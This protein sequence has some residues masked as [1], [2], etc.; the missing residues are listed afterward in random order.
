MKI[1]AALSRQK[2]LWVCGLLA[3]CS[4][5]VVS[6]GAQSVAPRISSEIN[7]AETSVVRNSLHPLAQAQYDAGRMPADRR[8]NGISIVFNRSAA[9]E[10]DLQ[11]LIAAQQ[12]PSS[13]L[14]HQ[15]LTP[16]QFAVRFG[17]ADAD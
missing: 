8:L 1:I 16:D 9:Q 4:M 13:P 7:S 17:M 10:A 11:G 2:F 5:I 14:F 12:N 3:A 15:W 6:A